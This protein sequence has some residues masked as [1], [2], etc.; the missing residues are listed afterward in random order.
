[1]S[2]MTAG[3]SWSRAVAPA[4]PGPTFER[5]WARGAAFSANALVLGWYVGSDDAATLEG[6]WDSKPLRA[7][8]RM[9]V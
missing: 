6:E 7:A 2:E 9:M 3:S 4:D 1:M 8:L 5:R